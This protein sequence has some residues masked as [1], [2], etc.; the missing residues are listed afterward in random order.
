M[1]SAPTSTG[2]SGPATPTNQRSG[3]APL[4]ADPSEALHVIQRDF[5]CESEKSGVRLQYVHVAVHRRRAS[6]GG[7][8][9]PQNGHG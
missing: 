2:N 6:S 7:N 5:R 1:V 8:E 3:A 9:V 4:P